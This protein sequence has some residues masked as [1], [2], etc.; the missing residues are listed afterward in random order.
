MKKLKSLI[1]DFKASII[2][3]SS[4]L[5]FLMVANA[6]GFGLFYAFFGLFI[7]MT[8][9]MFDAECYERDHHYHKERITKLEN[10]LRQLRKRNNL[11]S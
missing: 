2:M 6:T 11:Q 7:F 5:F 3:G 8:V 1:Q 9:Y 10:E 4:A